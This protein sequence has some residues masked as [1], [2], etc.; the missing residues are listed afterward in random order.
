ML[1]NPIGLFVKPD[2]QLQSFLQIMSEN[3]IST[4]HLLC[5]PEPERTPETAQKLQTLFQN[6]GIS[7]TALYCGF[8]GE[9]YA[10]IPLVETTVGLAPA[11][12]HD[13]RLRECLQIAD[14]ASD[15]G[16]PAVA[17]HVGFI[18]EDRKNE[19]HTRLIN[20]LRELCDHCHPK[21]MYVFL[22]TGQEKAKTLLDFLGEVDRVNL[23][24]NFDPA[25]MVLYGTGEPVSAL[26]L[27]GNYVKGVHI[28]DAKWSDQPGVEWGTEVVPGTGDV[29][30]DLII[31]T[32][33]ELDFTA[34][35]TIEREIT[36]DKRPDI[37]QTLDFI[38]KCR[39]EFA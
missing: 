8:D 31:R 23:A 13:S 14:F 26:R 27:L 9:S 7:V 34:P 5:P 36:G 10:S 17:L 37:L 1:N 16:I 29:K 20:S 12:T 4:A 39:Q 38:E 24:V 28:K 19:T 32:L 2:E 35:L 25:N 6:A 15:L 22:E 18:P 11:A 30:M 21:N 33:L 3:N